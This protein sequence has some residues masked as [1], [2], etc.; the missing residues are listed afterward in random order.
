MIERIQ[1]LLK[2]EVHT[3]AVQDMQFEG[4]HPALYIHVDYL[5]EV[6]RFLRD[7]KA[8]YFDF[9][10]DIAVVDYHPADYFEVVYHLTSIPYQTQL[11]LKVKLP[12]DR[13]PD[14]L[15][16]LPSVSGVWKTAEWHEREAYDLMGV[17]FTGHPDLRR[18]LMPDD[19]EGFP[20]RKDYEDPDNY[21]G[22]PIN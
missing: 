10:S 17:F 13:S 5:V 2:S 11:T 8:F 6:C 7:D 12:A 14:H 4:L 20:L 18:I 3:E 21:H 15:P 1:L 22:I 19:W 9:L 16:E